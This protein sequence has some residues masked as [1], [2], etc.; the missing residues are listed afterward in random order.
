MQTSRLIRIGV[1]PILL[2]LLAGCTSYGVIDNSP[3][4]TVHHNGYSWNHWAQGDHNDD[5]TVM[6]SFSG[7]GTRA[8][9]LSYGVLQALRDTTIEVDGRSVRLLDEVDYIS[10]VSG[11]SFTAAYYGLHRDGIFETFEDA[12]LLRDV[13]NRLF[14][15]LANPI[16]WFRSGGRT[17]MAIRYYNEHVFHDATFADMNLKEGPLILINASDLG[18]GVRFSF[19]QE[20]FN[21]ICSDIDD[22]PVAKAVAA[23][24]AVPVVFLPVVLQNYPDCGGA[25]PPWLKTAKQRAASDPLT[26]EMT[27]GIDS[28]LAKDRRKYMHLVDGGITDNLGLHALYDIITLA[29]GPKASLSKHK[30]R[31][32][33]QVIVISVNAST[34]PEPTMDLTNAE[35]SIGE[36][37]GAMSDVQLH[38]YNTSTLE[39]MKQSLRRW[40]NELKTPEHSVDTHFIRVG[41]RSVKNPAHRVFFNKIPTSFALSQDQ[42]DRL[43]RGGRN[44]LLD[45]P[46]YQQAV[47]ELGGH[48]DRGVEPE[49][50][51]Q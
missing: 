3:T 38:R 21:L 18:G 46:E 7:G 49:P 15:G 17:E 31:P 42:V 12:F 23:S 47:A 8:A 22:F 5:L 51:T 48:I 39:L 24:S 44:L 19:I 16:E 35:P 4:P 34:D 30:Q 27:D 40:A 29:G 2:L 25:E 26:A 6:L 9:A 28:L 13:E 37:I 50:D 1:M 14:W 20:Y 43:V 41:L 32:P 33:K 36:T 11:G 45:D 10:S